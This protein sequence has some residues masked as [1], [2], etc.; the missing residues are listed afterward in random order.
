MM[1]GLERPGLMAVTYPY[2]TGLEIAGSSVDSYPLV[3][4]MS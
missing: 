2:R 4:S 1:P 3:L